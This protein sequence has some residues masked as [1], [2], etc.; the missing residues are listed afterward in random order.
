MYINRTIHKFQVNREKFK[1]TEE[2]RPLGYNF[3]LP[4]KCLGLGISVW[5]TNLYF[6]SSMTILDELPFEIV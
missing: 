1:G 2:P 3:C 6:E 4:S 5:L